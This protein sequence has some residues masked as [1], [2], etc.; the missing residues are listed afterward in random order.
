MALLVVLTLTFLN[1]MSTFNDIFIILQNP[2]LD[3]NERWENISRLAAAE[4]AYRKKDDVLSVVNYNRFREKVK[5]Q[6]EGVRHDME[7]TNKNTTATV[8]DMRRRVGAAE[9]AIV[10][11]KDELERL[12][13]SHDKILNKQVKQ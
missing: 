5:R 9:N 3:D 11:L 6:F 1:N 12:K 4:C 10:E 8:Q 13:W 2:A 7:N